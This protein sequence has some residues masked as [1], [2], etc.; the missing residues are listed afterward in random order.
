MLHAHAMDDVLTMV[1]ALSATKLERVL[2]DATHI[3]QKK[4]GI[5]DMRETQEPL[6][7]LLNRPELKS[8][9]GSSSG[10]IQLMLY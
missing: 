5:F 1:G 7:L 2:V 4:R 10:T 6:I 3:D 9:F 8:R